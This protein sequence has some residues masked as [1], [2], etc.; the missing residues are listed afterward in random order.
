[1]SRLRVSL[2]AAI[3]SIFLIG[4]SPATSSPGQKFPHPHSASSTFDLDFSILPDD[5]RNHLKSQGF[6]FEQQM[7][8]ES[9]IHLSAENGRLNIV[10]DGPALGVLVN[11]DLHITHPEL[12]EIAWGVERYPQSADWQGGRKNEAVMVVL[13]FGDPLPGAQFYLPDMPLFLGMFLGDSDPPHKAFASENYSETGRYVCME[14][15]PAGQTIV[16]RLDIRDA[17]RDWFGNRAIPPVTG[18][19][20]EVDTGDLSGEAVSSSAFIHHIG[21]IKAD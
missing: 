13:F 3:F 14:N 8:D 5:V 20:I 15:P 21:L 10:T 11:K 12:L 4:F 9:A 2:S 1:M 6:T 7:G 16:T 19:A 17:F 18:I